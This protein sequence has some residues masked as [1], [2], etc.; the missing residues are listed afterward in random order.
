MLVDLAKTLGFTPFLGKGLDHADAGNG[1]GQHIGHIGPDPVDFFK[2]GAQLVAHHMN[3]PGDKRQGQQGHQ[4]QPGADGKQNDS[5]HDNH[6]H[7]GG[8][9]QRVQRQEHANTVSLRANAGHQ[10]AGAL[11]AKVVQRQLQ[12]MVKRGGAQ[13]GAYA[14]GHQCQQ[15]GARPVQG[16]A[17][18]RRTQQAAQNGQDLPGLDLLAVLE[19]NQDVVHQRNRQVGRHQRGRGRGQRQQKTGQQLVAIGMGKAPQA[20]QHPGRRRRMQRAGAGR[21]YLAVGRQRQIAFRA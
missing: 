1:V 5:G 14:F 2:A 11:A 3:H 7:I 21:A 20:Q 13:V 6:Q 12:Q 18:Q 8:K 4:R 16:P 9:V 10:V 15:I 17:Q 19:R